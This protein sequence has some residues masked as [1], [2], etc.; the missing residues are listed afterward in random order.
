MPAKR[1][2]P[3]KLLQQEL[4]MFHKIMEGLRRELSF[5][6]LLKLIITCVTQ[7]LGYD[8]AGLFL[9][10]ES[11]KRLRQV[12]GIDT[13][14]RFETDAKIA[15]PVV[16][17]RG[18]SIMSDL[19]QGYRKFF[20]TH[21]IRKK[22]PG[23]NVARG[24]TSNA[25]VPVQVSA[26]R[27]IGVLAVDNLFTQRRITRRDVMVL[28]NFATQAGLVIESIRLHE[29]VR[30]L[31]VTDEL[32]GLFNR[33]YFERRLEEE[34]VR[35][36]R[37]SR[38]L[39]FLYIDLD[40]FKSINDRFGHT[41]GDEVL[42][43]CAKLLQTSTRS[44]D[45]VARIGGEEFAV[46]LPETPQEGAVTLAERLVKRFASSRP[47]LPGLDT[48]VTL[49]IGVAA[50]PKQKSKDELYRVADQRLY[51]AKALGRNQVGPLRILQ[52]STGK[53]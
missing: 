29:E 37:Y 17:R 8:R 4:E 48:R 31:S 45:T 34:L 39:S 13:Q 23:A 26:K 47:P 43:F 46:L 30:Q 20:F 18:A 32:T 33:R 25:N 41:A 2:L 3:W 14:G 12:I 28:K 51:Q 6:D 16:R 52:R 38:P 9:L 40:R 35:A 1:R 49:S 5:P 42:R 24:V 53:K 19:V 7:G 36:R 44:V 15:F 22:L 27:I 11:R 50:Y 21:H 10:D